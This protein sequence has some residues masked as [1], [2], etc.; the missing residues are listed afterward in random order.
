MACA[1]ALAKTLAGE[2]SAVHYPAM[3]VVVKTPD[4]P[5]VFSVPYD[6]HQADWH[7]EQNEEGVRSLLTDA[8][9]HL[10]GFALT[11]KRVAEKQPLIQRLPA[12]MP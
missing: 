8:Q 3:P 5:L 12:V 10:L 7:S 4:C 1:R 2:E 11:H 6:S 9:G